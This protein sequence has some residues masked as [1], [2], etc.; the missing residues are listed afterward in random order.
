[1]DEGARA[2]LNDRCG[3]GQFAGLVTKDLQ[4]ANRM[5]RPFGQSGGRIVMSA[6]LHVHNDNEQR[7]SDMPS[8]FPQAVSPPTA[9]MYA[10]PWARDAATDAADAAIGASEKLR[11]ALP[12]A[13]LLQEPE[14]RRRGAAA[15][16]GDVALRELRAR[17]ALDPDTV[18]EPPVVGSRKSSYSLLGR[19]VG[20]GALAGLAALFMVGTAP[21]SL[22][23][24]ASTGE[25]GAQPFWSRLFGASVVREALTPP[26][27]LAERRTE[28]VADRPVPMMERF[29]A[30]APV[31]EPPA[32][33]A[34]PPQAQVQTQAV[35][36]PAQP[37]PAAQPPAP[38]PAFSPPVR[39]LDR[40]EIAALYR[41][42]EQLIQQ[43][44][45][46]AARLMFGRAA[47]VGDARSALALGASY[48]PDVL[49]KLGVLG[50]AADPVLAREWY[51]KASS[52]GSREAAQRIELLALGR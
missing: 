47:E 32:M 23:G 6:P 12:P 27:P 50:V 30:A 21:G 10:P 19:L 42:G 13:P 15:F 18:P 37:A 25:D 34:Q 28:P 22:R 14:R 38:A 51:S 24:G 49:R 31:A 33:A 29:A 7:G 5:C 48:D 26:K 45:I 17:P 36:P 20:A 9:R 16:E 3:E 2:P 43:G 1:M 39:T 52:Y 40:D 35:E 11:S 8:M 41:R 46:A 4:G 44:D